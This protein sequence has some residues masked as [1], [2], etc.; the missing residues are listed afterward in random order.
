MRRPRW[1]KLVGRLCQ[2]PLITNWRFTETPYNRRFSLGFT[3]IVAAAT[4]HNFEK[5]I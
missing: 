2:T 3:Q 1:F 5:L 4:N